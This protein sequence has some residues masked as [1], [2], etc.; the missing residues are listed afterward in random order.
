MSV[1]LVFTIELAWNNHKQEIVKKSFSS[2]PNHAMNSAGLSV[3]T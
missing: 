2:D 1:I 3:V